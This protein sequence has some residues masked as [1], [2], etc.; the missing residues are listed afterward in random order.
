MCL[1]SVRQSNSAAAR[2]A[3]LRVPR[4]P[5]QVP[6]ALPRARAG[7]LPAIHCPEYGAVRTSYYL[8]TV[9]LPYLE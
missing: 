5:A 3:G 7:Q 1:R 6:Q 4:L 9:L 2:Q 8:L